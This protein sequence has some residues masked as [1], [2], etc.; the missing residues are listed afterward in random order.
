MIRLKTAFF[1]ASTLLAASFLGAC[2]FGGFKVDDAQLRYA[3]KFPEGI[4]YA[5]R[6]NGKVWMVPAKNTFIGGAR[7]VSSQP[8][9]V[10]TEGSYFTI[11]AAPA[12]FYVTVD[13]K[14]ELIS[15]PI[16]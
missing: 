15:I 13:G 3:D 5:W 11:S 16:N 9:E 6:Q 8:L 1:G 12:S 14:Q 4:S 7:S 2:S 10:K